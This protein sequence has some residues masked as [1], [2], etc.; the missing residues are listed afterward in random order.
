LAYSTQTDLLRVV[1]E[2][3]LSQLTSEIDGEIATDV[4]D[5]AIAD[6]DADIDGYVAV[7]YEVP[8][9]PVPKMVQRISTTIA[10][11]HLYSRR[12]NRIGGMSEV[13]QKNYDNAIKTLKD[14]SKG[15]VSLGVDPPPGNTSTSVD[16]FE[17]DE[18][19]YT[20]DSMKGF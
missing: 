2:I 7:R 1:S 3:E 13:V 20:K 16:D 11:Y 18:R 8:L 9:S 17:A 5:G 15:S 4:V 12:Q 6:A 10:L 19:D 14:V